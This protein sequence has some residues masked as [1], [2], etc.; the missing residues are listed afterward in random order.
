MER[1]STLTNELAMRG[2][3]VH[4]KVYAEPIVG[5]IKNL[6]VLYGGC[7]AIAA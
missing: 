3:D 2:I 1:S 6:V 4:G 7:H 5:F